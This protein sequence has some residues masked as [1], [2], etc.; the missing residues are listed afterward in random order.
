MQPHLHHLSPPRAV[1]HLPTWCCPTKLGPTGQS[2]LRCRRGHPELST[3]HPRQGNEEPPGTRRA[4]VHSASLRTCS[5]SVDINS[6]AKS[7][8]QVSPKKRIY[9]LQDF[10]FKKSIVAA[11]KVLSSAAEK[12]LQNLIVCTCTRSFKKAV[13][14]STPDCC[15]LPSPA[16]LSSEQIQHQTSP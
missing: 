3:C 5:H 15:N 16:T 14:F 6:S 11:N 7:N 1:L 2:T 9:F 10:A 13:L 4:E 8:D 12:K